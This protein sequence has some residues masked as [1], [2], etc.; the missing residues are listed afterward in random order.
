MASKKVFKSQANSGRASGGLG[1]FGNSAFGSSHSSALSYIQE[2]LD[3]S[4]ISDVNVVVSLKN[5]S[6]KDSVTKARALEE[7]QTYVAKPD[8]DVEEGLVE[9]W[10]RLYPR[11]SIDNARRVRHLAHT[12]SG[13]IFAKCGKRAARHL[14]KVAGPWLAGR[15]DNDR[16]AGKAAQDALSLVFANPEKIMGLKKTF[17]GPILEYCRDA[18]LH[19][20]AQTLSDE[21]AVSVD[22]AAATYA[23]VLAASLAVVTEMLNDLPR[24]EG[25]KQESVYEELLGETKLWELAC[26]TETGVRRSTHRL[27]QA[28]LQ[29]QPIL[30]ETN[31]K[32][33]STIYIYKGLPSDQTGSSIDYLAALDA[34]TVQMPA[35]WTDDYSGK[36]SA[37]SRFKQ[38]WKHGSRSGSGEF[39]AVTSNLLAKVP[40]E[41]WPA[42]YKEA[43]DLLLAARDGVTR[44]EER[45]NASTAWGAYFSLLTVLSRRLSHEDQAK[46][47]AECAMPI[48]QEYLKPSQDTADWAIHGAKTAHMVAGVT[49]VPSILPLLEQALPELAEHITETAR[50]SQPQQSKDFDKSQL[51]VAS[52]GERW[53][54]MQRELFTKDLPETLLAT[55]VASNIKL[56]QDCHQILVNRDG[57]PFGAAAVIEELVRTCGQRLLKDLDF[58]NAIKD[59][60]EADD[61]K[62]VLW[63]SSRQLI[64]CLHGLA[65]DSIFV[66]PFETA[67]Q[68]ALTKAESLEDSSRLVRELLPRNA[69]DEAVEL[70]RNNEALQAFILQNVKPGL[71]ATSGTMLLELYSI[72]ALSTQTIQQAFSSLVAGLADT[73]DETELTSTLDFLASSN[74]S[75][76]KDVSALPGC[77]QLVSH[78]LRLE[79]HRN[80]EIAQKAASLSSRLS[81][82][83]TKI[84][85]GAKFSV[86]LQ[87]LDH[88]SEQ[89]LPMDSL[90]ELLDRVLGEDK[91]VQ[92]LKTAMPDL[93]AWRT[94]LLAAV[95]PPKLSLSILSPLGAAVNFAQDVMSQTTAPV[96]VDSEGLCQALR[97]AIYI[98]RLLSITDARTGLVELEEQW[99]VLAML[100]LVVQ[101]A[102]DN[103]S[104]VGTNALWHPNA[105]AVAEAIVLDFVSDAHRLLG[106][107]WESMQPTDVSEESVKTGCA[108]MVAA[109]EQ[110][111]HD[112]SHQS[113]LAYY[114]ALSYSKITSN[115]Y[116]LH[117]HNADNT[118]SSEAGLR[119]AKAKKDSLRTVAYLVANQLPLASSPSLTRFCNEL[120][121]D[122]TTLDVTMP[123]KGLKA[124]EQ[125]IML[126]T[127]LQTQEDAVDTI[128][129]QRLIFL[130]KGL[131]DKLS[132]IESST[133]KSEGYKALGYLLP[134]MS[135]MYGEHWSQ[136]LER[137]EG[138]WDWLA[139][140]KIDDVLKEEHIVLEHTSLKLLGIL[141]RLAN[142]DDPNDDLVDALKNKESSVHSHLMSLLE[143]ANGDSDEQHQAL[144]VTHEQLARQLAQAPYKQL[145]EAN[146]LFP[147]LYTPSRAIQQGA[148]DLLHKQIPAV[149][150]QIS[151]D[152]ALDNKSV[153]LPD[154]LLSLI[155][156]AP[157][158]DSLVDASFDRTMPLSLQGYLYSWRLLFDHF[159]GSSYRVKT[160]YIEQLKDGAYLSGL[161]SFTFDFLGHSRGKPIDASRF[162]IETYTADSEPNPERDV[163]WLLTHLYYLTM[164]HLPSLAKSYYLDIR[165]R[166]TSLAV[167]SWTGKYISPL[168]INAAL[169]DVAEWAETSVKEEPEYEKMHVRVGMRSKEINVSYEIDEQTMA[170]KVI[171]PE[172][173]PLAAAQV[174]GVSRVAVKED[175]WQSWLRNCQGVITFSNGSITDG[176]S[177]WR[178]NVVGALKGQTECAICY[179][180]IDSTKQLPTKKC[181]T[182]KNLFHGNC[183]YKWFKTSNAS[184]C[185]L[186]RNAFSFA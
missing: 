168:V 54:T 45:F 39:W 84:Q 5:L 2:P 75:I 58:R 130:V 22:D 27:V 17:Q 107:Y 185:P 12:V 34:L 81:S 146:E 4:T 110:L 160:D 147:L 154:E 38:F 6:K 158:L 61:C 122:L 36:K 97:T 172:A 115:L 151:F 82:S 9:A 23:R 16:A 95:R 21:R 148:F 176:L 78:L 175:K 67:L 32:V 125:L 114:V 145:P 143:H 19:E 14:P 113:P 71:S 53:A 47:A 37:A 180:I 98:T 123:E 159:S 182:C 171:L 26:Y 186:C 153:H 74:N 118:A 152:A 120:V 90:S 46:V 79:H 18:A 20:T 169:Q 116:E 183:L 144:L 101:L 13:N 30:V 129:K 15:H 40:A 136:V 91:H 83:G 106:S 181:P 33:I 3:F 35:I 157:T 8:T 87:N 29:K 133:I 117:G 43:Q 119:A 96:N 100:Y 149:Q 103:L 76:L 139:N 68:V 55:L 59:I 69:P 62:W 49:K 50:L 93:T 167:E 73:Y 184:T 121:A 89:S 127:I 140:E 112:E 163:Q 178:K 10:V 86:V 56:V 70:A 137:L 156:E 44:K 41:V 60:L 1:A 141:R 177:A 72:K 111:G 28:A 57:K 48:I 25:S 126:N 80:D 170:I 179:S 105:G 108:A 42:E 63:P 174:V 128:A 132:H 88:V 155:L 138:T 131:I 85:G 31:R 104:V 134:A 7:I 65:Q 173:Y 135:D 162:D 52:T 51:H 164:T 124:Q 161:L 150:E 77:E 94:S 109:M 165:S 99:H 142:S 66:E 166:Q 64:R 11:L 92:D 24:E 102:E